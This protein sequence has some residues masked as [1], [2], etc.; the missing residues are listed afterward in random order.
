MSSSKVQGRNLEVGVKVDTLATLVGVGRC[1]GLVIEAFVSE[2]NEMV[3]IDRLDVG[4]NILCPGGD[5][6]SCA[7]AR[8]DAGIE[9]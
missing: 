9:N 2:A 8:L 7:G 3:G 6:G 5:C 1:T 4:R